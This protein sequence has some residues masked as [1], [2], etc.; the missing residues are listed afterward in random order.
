MMESN[1]KIR[2]FT[3]TVVSD[4]MDKTVVVRVERREMH[5]RYG[6]QVTTHRTFKA[7]D[8]TNECTVGDRVVIAADRPRSREKRWRVVRRLSQQSTINSQQT[9]DEN[10]KL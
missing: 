3:G 2:Q 7:H 9:T 4:K 6:K 1:N 10:E 5:P 8:E